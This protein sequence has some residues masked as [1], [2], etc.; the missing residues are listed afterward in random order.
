MSEMTIY[1]SVYV[2]QRYREG[3]YSPGVD[4]EV[5]YPKIHFTKGEA[6]AHL[7]ANPPTVT[8]K[9]QDWRAAGRALKEKGK[10]ANPWR[11]SHT[12]D[13][14]VYRAQLWIHGRARKPKPKGP[15]PTRLN[16]Y[17]LLTDD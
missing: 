12:N 8:I 5:R 14:W 16:R 1:R 6:W 7:R 11:H 17:A 10:Y 4:I 3:R 15:P 13:L 2:P 9:G